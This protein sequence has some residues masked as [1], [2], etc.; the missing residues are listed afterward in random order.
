MAT[1]P[2]DAKGTEELISCADQA[3]YEAKAK[4]KNKVCVYRRSVKELAGV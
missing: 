4:G 2:D 1:C 3:L